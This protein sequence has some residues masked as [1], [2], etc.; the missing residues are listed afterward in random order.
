MSDN[1]NILLLAVAAAIIIRRRRR[2][3][4]ALVGRV[5]SRKWLLLRTSD[6]GMHSF[7]MNELMVPDAGGFHSFLRMTPEQFLELLRHVEPLI[8]RSET[9]LR[10]NITAHEMVVLTLRYLA[11]GNV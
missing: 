1:N 4:A 9:V 3:R 6:R 2:R 10:V 8:Q 5:W 7:V 11:S